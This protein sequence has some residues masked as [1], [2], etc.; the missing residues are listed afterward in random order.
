MSTGLPKVIRLSI[1]LSPAKRGGLVAEHAALRVTG[2][3]DVAT[4][5]LPDLSDGVRD[6]DDVIGQGALEP[7]LLALGGA[8]VDDPGIDPAIA[9]H[10]YGARRGRD[11]IDV[12][13]EHQRRHEQCRRTGRVGAPGG[14]AIPAQAV[15]ALLGDD[16]VGAGL[17]A[18]VE[19]AEARDFDRVLRGCGELRTDL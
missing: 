7:T 18:R 12:G 15:D 14:R 4:R 9:K 16:V 1:A 19:S 6:R 5:R 10:R 3:V 2:E 13:G 8:E 11:V 17:L